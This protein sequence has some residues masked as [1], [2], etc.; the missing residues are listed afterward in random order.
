MNGDDTPHANIDS[1]L[2]QLDAYNWLERESNYPEE[3]LSPGEMKESIIEGEKFTREWFQHPE[4]QK[5][6]LKFRDPESLIPLTEQW[7]DIDVQVNYPR[8]TETPEEQLKEG[9]EDA[10][11]ALQA[12]WLIGKPLAE[13]GLLGGEK[14]TW[15]PWGLI[16]GLAGMEALK[17]FGGDTIK[18]FADLLG[19]K[20]KWGPPEKILPMDPYG[21][22]D[23]REMF[24]K[25]IYGERLSSP[26]ITFKTQRRGGLEEEGHTMSGV[27]VH[28][29][30]HHAQKLVGGITQKEKNLMDYFRRQKFQ[31]GTSGGVPYPGAI[32]LIPTEAYED[33]ARLMVI[34]KAMYDRGIIEGPGEIIG[35]DKFNKLKESFGKGSQPGYLKYLKERYKDENV[36][37]LLNIIAAIPEDEDNGLQFA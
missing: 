28:E 11:S 36:V 21:V 16:S 23:E 17:R 25:D 34:R 30:G 33:H 20:P 1:L 12:S 10:I 15:Q 24:E 18:K 14:K 22:Y 29:F 26:K 2:A 31:S 6:L 35:M 8:I 19:I 13:S 5:R 4:T 32:D 37:M 7:S 27:A 9:Y 3:Y